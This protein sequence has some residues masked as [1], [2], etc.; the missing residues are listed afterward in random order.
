MDATANPH[1]MCDSLIHW[2]HTLRLQAPH[3]NA[4]EL[5]DGVAMA[6]ALHQIA[7]DHFPASWLAKIKF[8]V[9]ITHLI[10]KTDKHEFFFV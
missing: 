4:P 1:A 5:S 3:R 2:L 8:E 10:S 6:Q 9:G 7:P